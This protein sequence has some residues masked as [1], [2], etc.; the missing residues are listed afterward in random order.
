MAEVALNLDGVK[1]TVDVEELMDGSAPTHGHD[2]RF[3]H[4]KFNHPDLAVSSVDLAAAIAS[5]PYAFYDQCRDVSVF[6][7]PQGMGVS[8]NLWDRVRK[9]LQN[10]VL[11]IRE[12]HAAKGTIPVCAMFLVAW[13]GDYTE[14]LLDFRMCTSTHV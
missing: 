9:N 14:E 7:L 3:F 4:V 2:V 12:V 13:Y 6:K 8:P 1:G 5:Q 11:T 10:D